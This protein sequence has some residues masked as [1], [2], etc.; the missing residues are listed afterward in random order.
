MEVAALVMGIIAIF[1]GFLG[2]S[3]FVGPIC[4]ILAIIFGV[5][6]MKKNSDKKGMAKAGMIMGIVSIAISIVVTVACVACIGV[7]A[8]ALAND[9]SF[10]ELLNF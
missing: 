5:L 10:M 4:A 1:G 2:V 8:A 9:P 6:G 7:G 3:G